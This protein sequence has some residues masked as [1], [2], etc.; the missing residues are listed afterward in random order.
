MFGIIVAAVY[1]NGFK[2]G[3]HAVHTEETIWKLGGVELQLEAQ[4][5]PKCLM[6]ALARGHRDER[7]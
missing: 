5:A 1:H 7:S 6:E 3:L 4:G 2:E